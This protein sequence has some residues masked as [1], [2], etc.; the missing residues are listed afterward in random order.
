MENTMKKEFSLIVLAFLL[1]LPITIYGQVAINTDG[2]A[3]ASGAILHVKG[4]GNNNFFIDDATGEVGINTVSPTSELDVNGVVRIRGG[5][6]GNFKVLTS[7]DAN[8]NTTWQPTRTIEYPDGQFPFIAVTHSFY[9][10][11]YTVPAGKNLYITLIY[12]EGS[13]AYRLYINGKMISYGYSNYMA[14]NSTEGPIIA[15]AGDVIQ[16]SASRISISGFLVDAIVT[17]VTTTESYTVSAGYNFVIQSICSPSGAKVLDVDGRT[18]YYGYGNY[19]SGDGSNYHGLKDPLFV[20]SG[21][22]VT[23][24]GGTINGYLIPE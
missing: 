23:F 17:P 5:S 20:G 14:F 22:T 11:S 24:N 13:S 10:G 3:S 9:N 18:Y 4:S 12:S 8:G 16:Y 15:G 21:S 7:Y 19:N 6:P 1:V 2:S